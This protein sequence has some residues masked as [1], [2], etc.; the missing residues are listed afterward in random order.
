MLRTATTFIHYNFAFDPRR[1]EEFRAN[2]LSRRW[3]T[4]YPHLFSRHDLRLAD[5]QPRNH[6]YE[7]LGAVLLYEATGYHSHLKWCNERT[8]P[9][10]VATLR[11][12]VGADLAE[13]I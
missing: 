6:F 2:A 7:W 9:R 3:F 12:L 5:N 11:R 10:K 4:V 1:R 13:E 8:E